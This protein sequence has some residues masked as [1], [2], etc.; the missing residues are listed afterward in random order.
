ER[1]GIVTHISNDL[2][3]E[4][5][6]RSGA[7]KERKAGIELH[8]NV[9]DQVED[10]EELFTVYSEKEEKLEE[11]IE[12]AEETEAVRVRGKE[13]SLVERV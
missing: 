11:A 12:V 2:M 5:S 8:M 13:A 10:G 4:I 6:R 1:D 3:S 7:P 9:G